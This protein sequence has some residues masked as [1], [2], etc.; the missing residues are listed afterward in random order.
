MHTVQNPLH[1]YG[2][3]NGSLSLLVCTL[4]LPLVLRF[5]DRWQLQDLP[6][7]LKPHAAPTPRLGGVAM[8]SA[9]VVGISAGGTGLFSPAILIFS[10]CCWCGSQASWMT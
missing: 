6:G 9:L 3:F 1:F 7:D 10:R 4:L 5:A 8:G 2:W